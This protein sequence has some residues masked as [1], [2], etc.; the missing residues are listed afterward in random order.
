MKIPKLL[1]VMSII[2]IL[3]FLILGLVVLI[4]PVGFLDPIPLKEHMS[5][6]GF[7]QFGGSFIVLGI[8][9]IIIFLTKDL[10]SIKQM[11][12]LPVLIA[13]S[14]SVIDIYDYTH[15][16]QITQYFNVMLTKIAPVII[17]AIINV[18]VYLFVNIR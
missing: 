7:K 6:H 13:I 5:M 14:I 18:I 8:L 2:N 12:L 10:K 11:L 17:Y 15:L 3:Y 16:E 1:L 9:S 4:D